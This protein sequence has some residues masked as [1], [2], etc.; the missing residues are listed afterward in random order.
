MSSFPFFPV[1]APGET[2][3]SVFARCRARVGVQKHLL[4]HFTDQPRAQALLS[5]IPGRVSEISARVPDGHPWKN[6]GVIVWEHTN[7]P[8]FVYFDL[9]GQNAHLAKKGGDHPVGWHAELALGISRRR[10]SGR[11]PHPRFCPACVVESRR[12]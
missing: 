11:A 3:Y 4:G 7:L 2:V 5:A 6:P 10:Y 1:P 9:L 8:Y 12:E